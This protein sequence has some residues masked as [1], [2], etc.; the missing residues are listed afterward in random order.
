MNVMAETFAALLQKPF[1]QAAFFLLLTIPSILIIGPKTAD[2]A[3]LIAGLVFIGFML[4]NALYI[5]FISDTWRYFFYSL[6]GSV[7]YLCVIAVLM[8]AL[9]KALS[10]EGSAE[11]AMVF[12][13]IIYHPVFLL[14]VVFLKWAYVKAF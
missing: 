4:T 8:P 1:I 12:I 9:L 6:G 5:A 10:I 14:L 13:S 3:W 11:S 7:V 2:K